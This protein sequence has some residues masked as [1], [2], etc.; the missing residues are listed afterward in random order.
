[1]IDFTA[2]TAIQSSI[3]NDLDIESLKTR[4]VL[5]HHFDASS[6]ADLDAVTEDFT[7]QSVLVTEDASFIGLKAIRNFY[8]S[9]LQLFSKGFVSYKLKKVAVVKDI[10]YITW[11]LKTSE[12]EIPFGTDTFIIENDK[13][14][15]QTG[16]AYII[17]SEKI[18]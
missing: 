16:G 3:Q 14:L 4:S 17:P 2:L 12:F 18:I 1:M 6:K 13:I 5:Q 15:Y 10:A 8:T 11:Q 7:E 9:L